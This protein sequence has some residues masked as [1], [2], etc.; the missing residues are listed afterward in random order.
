MYESLNLI[1]KY[2][3]M[4]WRFR[5][6]ALI[7]AT[8][9]CICGWSAVLVLP[10][11][12]K[13]TAKVYLDTKTLLRPL[14][15][16][17]A[18]D[19]TSQ[20][21]EALTMRRTLLVRPNLE[22]VARKTDMDLQAHT[23]EDFERL[24]NGLAK[25]ISVSGTSRDNIFVISYS[26]TDAKLATRVVDSL[27]NLFV[28]RSLG[29]SRKDSSKSREFLESQ[30]KEYEAR[31]IA[32]ES[33][34]KEFKRQ[35]VGL[36][37]SDGSSYYAR[38]EEVSERTKEAQLELKEAEQRR[39]ELGRQLAT[40]SAL[41][42]SG[43]E[44]DISGLVRNPLDE[45]IA[46]LE[47]NLDQLLLQYTEQHPDV[48]QVQTVLARLTQKRAEELA[49]Q[50]DEDDGTQVSRQQTANPIYQELKVGLGATEAEVAALTAR[51]E[52]YM[53]R[54][55]ELTELVDTI[56]KVEAELFKLNRDYDIDQHNYSALVARRESLKIS[57]DASQST[58]AVQFN[59][60]EPPKEPLVPTSPDR[61]RLNIGV[62]V[63]GLGVGILIAVGVGM[64]RPVIYTK[65]DFSELT[66]IP[67]LGTVSRVYTKGELVRRRVEAL[68]FGFACLCLLG[69][70]TGL[71]ALEVLNIDLVTKMSV[72][73]ERL[74]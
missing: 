14:L 26:N 52:E 9:I 40:V 50:A 67:I 57:D 10:N 1:H 49:K 36:M 27:L 66:D 59:I 42:E 22:Q 16:G 48:I 63:A 21:D 45:R 72:L 4:I 38:L 39:D 24:L 25:Q 33:R 34:M 54:Q 69:I 31:L 46:E 6:V 19:A 44:G 28:E 15:K 23:P 8:I 29:E 5:W 35:N 61:P 30:I 62:L 60:I 11:M 73:R 64:L 71:V 32:A 56:P 43:A 47:S 7:S 37:P 3:R 53:Q 74:I 20:Q 70:Y 18:V 55:I 51:V 2:L 41:L 65:E 12:Y 68:T 17:I 58:D 13:V